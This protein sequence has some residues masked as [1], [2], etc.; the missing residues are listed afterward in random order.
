VADVAPSD[1]SDRAGAPAARPCRLFVFLAR[2]APLG[3]V[4]RR[5]PSDWFRLSL[6]RTDTDALEHGQW[7]SGRVY[8]RRSDLAPDGSLFVA[9]VRRSGGPLR[10]DPEAADS[11]VAI[12]RPPYFTALALWFVGG[13]YWLGGCFPEAPEATE[14]PAA[15]GGV[16]PATRPHAVFVGGGTWPP[17][18]GTL[19][20]W[21]TVTKD[22]PYVDPTHQTG[23]RLILHNRLLR[24]GWGREPGTGRALWE[25][26]RPGGG[27]TLAMEEL[28]WDARAYGGPYRVAY[29]VY[30]PGGGEL[31]PLEGATWADWDRRGRL[32][33]ARHG[34]LLAGPPGGPL[35]EIADFNG[36]QPEPAPAPAWARSWP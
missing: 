19:P 18:R 10:S 28:G 2:D 6:W 32:V 20:A 13:T 5:G 11:W 14:A 7:L 12:S 30:A 9:F 1:T 21:L 15:P 31:L 23:D 24:D 8:E 27:W 16:R 29:A 33:V 25:R 4:L 35:R 36:Q 3:L 34:R 22:L 26:R 17:S